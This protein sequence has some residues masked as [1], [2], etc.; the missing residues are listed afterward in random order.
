VKRALLSIALSLCV[1][2]T[3]PAAGLVSLTLHPAKIP[4]P[5]LKYPLLPDQRQLTNDDAAPLYREA[6]AAGERSQLLF[7]PELSQELL[8]TPL[9]KLP[10]KRLA[11]QLKAGNEMFALLDKAA[12]CE[13]CDWGLLEPL[14][15]EG[16]AA[17][18]RE[19]YR[20]VNSLWGLRLLLAIRVRLALAEGRIDDALKGLQTSLA[21]AQHAGQGHAQLYLDA[22][23]ALA[24]VRKQLDTYVEQPGAPN[25]Y[26][27][28]AALPRPLIDPRNALYGQRTALHNVVPGL[29]N[30]LNDSQAGALPAEDLQKCSRYLEAVALEK[31]ISTFADRKKFTELLMARHE[32][33]K[34]ALIAAGRPRDKVEAMPHLQVALLH[35]LFEFDRQYDDILKWRNS[36]YW[37]I[38]AFT[39]NEEEAQQSQKRAPDAPVIQ[40][41]KQFP[42]SPEQLY[43]RQA[44]LERDLTLYRTIEAVRHYAATHDGK[45]PPTLAAIKDVPLPLDPMTGK[46]FTY[47]LDG[48]TATLSAEAPANETPSSGNSATYELRIGKR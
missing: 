8:D 16:F 13:R 31:P 26:W 35:S 2:T 45:L 43:R 1:A 30:V 41:G 4:S 11:E 3:T 19:R 46:E 39:K 37:E 9:A 36:P 24:E 10:R 27:S 17:L 14:R 33:A 29:T 48:D 25:L 6:V 20:E 34:Q 18:N 15:K 28:L 44:Q 40:L 38:H 21:M 5:A 23:Y 22:G 32:T 42:G 47:Q 12:C 7:K